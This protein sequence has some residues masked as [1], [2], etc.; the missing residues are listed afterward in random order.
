MRTFQ[1]KNST[2]IITDDE[3]FK[4]IYGSGI[5]IELSDVREAVKVYE[6]YAK[7]R[8]LKVLVVFADDTT[9]TAEARQSAEIKTANS[10]AEAFVLKT[11]AQSILLR[12]Y[13]L[14]RKSLHPIKIFKQEDTAVKWLQSI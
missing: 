10:L 11:L 6:D 3:I 13:L 5:Q 1:N 2:I 8:S 4:L 9:M 12:F 14:R 7:G